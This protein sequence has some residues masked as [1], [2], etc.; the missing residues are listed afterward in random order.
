MGE[1]GNHE[2]GSNGA[3]PAAL[4]ACCTDPS[5]PAVAEVERLR[6][7]N[8]RMREALTEIRRWTITGTHERV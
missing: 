2:N 5:C 1:M 3:R 6:Q 7:E 4:D 8:R